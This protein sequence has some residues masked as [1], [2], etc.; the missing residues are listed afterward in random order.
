MISISVHHLRHLSTSVELISE[1]RLARQDYSRTTATGRPP[2]ASPGAATTL[3]EA[4]ESAWG[5]ETM[6]LQ[7]VWATVKILKERPRPGNESR[8]GATAMALGV[9]GSVGRVANSNRASKRWPG[10][11]PAAFTGSNAKRT[12][13]SALALM[14]V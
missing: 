12:I 4:E 1:R 3:E 9:H 7:P 10:V 11:H 14:L 6:A 13:K 2:N 5:D 8:G